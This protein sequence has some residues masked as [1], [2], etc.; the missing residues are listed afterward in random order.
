MQKKAIPPE[1]HDAPALPADF[2][3]CGSGIFRVRC[4]A[5]A[6][7]LFAGFCFY[8]ASQLSPSQNGYGTHRQL[9]YPACLMPLLTGYPCPT[10]GMTTAFAHA[11]RGQFFSAFNAQPAGLALAL[12]L[13]ACSLC[14][15]RVVVTGNYDFVRF[16]IQ[17][18]R[19]ALL[20]VAIVLFGWL[21]KFTTFSP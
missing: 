16:Q 4:T 13:F 14:C 6:L 1:H 20:V 12:G 15:I 19:I 10:C 11:V 17:P 8:I 7:L 5:L 3:L 21:Y 18:G 2:R 9:G